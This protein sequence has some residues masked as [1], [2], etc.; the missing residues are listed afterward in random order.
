MKINQ[1]TTYVFAEVAN[2]YKTNFEK[3]LNEIGLHSGQIFVLISL[4]E[5]DGLSQ[6]VL[7]DKLNL[8]PPTIYKMVQSL[9][10]NRYVECRQCQHD[11][12]SMRVYLTPKSLKQKDLIYAKWQEF[13]DSFFQS[14]TDT[15]KLI[16]FQLLDKIKQ[17]FLK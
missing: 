7:A 9:A 17:D 2:I 12:R 5:K 10:A 3:A 11:G 1:L 16:F 6:K 13:D 4:F 15:E 8:S 14:L